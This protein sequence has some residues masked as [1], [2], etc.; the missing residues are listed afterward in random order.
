VCFSEA[1][2]CARV[3]S[4]LQYTIPTRLQA[5]AAKVNYIDDALGSVIQK[6]HEKVGPFLQACLRSNSLGYHSGCMIRRGRGLTIL[7]HC[8]HVSLQGMWNNTLFILTADNGGPI[9]DN[10]NA[11][12]N[13]WPLRVSRTTW[14]LRV[15]RTTF[16]EPRPLFRKHRVLTQ[17]A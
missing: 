4:S 1:L 14:P 16:S 10:G 6:L 12:A 13:N 7:N 9:Y 5:Y 17:H 8:V 2:K 3:I 15:S 11:G